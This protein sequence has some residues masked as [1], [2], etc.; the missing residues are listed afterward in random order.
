MRSLS[1]EA[2]CPRTELDFRS[3]RHS[4]QAG[5]APTSRRLKVFGDFR[6]IRAAISKLCNLPRKLKGDYGPATGLSSDHLTSILM[7][8]WF[9]SLVQPSQ[10]AVFPSALQDSITHHPT[11]QCPLTLV[12]G[13]GAVHDMRTSRPGVFESP[14]LTLFGF[15]WSNLSNEM[16]FSNGWCVTGS[17]SK[18][19]STGLA[20]LSTGCAGGKIVGVRAMFFWGVAQCL[21]SVWK[22]QSCIS[23]TVRH[24]RSTI[25]KV[26]NRPIIAASA[27]SS[28]NPKCVLLC[29]AADTSLSFSATS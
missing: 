24:V 28:F 15:T 18:Y 1:A 21:S 12:T 3:A 5:P 2:C 27:A 9:P 22:A 26:R 14:P 19:F 8:P 4:E 11:R 7:V 20:G 25:T 13:P 16:I 29:E 6:P 23:G 10:L 17:S